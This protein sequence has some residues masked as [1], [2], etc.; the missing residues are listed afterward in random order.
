LQELQKLQDD[1][2]RFENAVAF[3]TV[4]EELGIDNFFDVFELVEMEPIA[5]ASIGQ[6]YKA[7]L[8]ENGATVAL[9]IQ[10][11]DCE[12]IIALDLYGKVICF[13]EFASFP[14]YNE[15]TSV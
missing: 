5:A 9:K 13:V 12:R 6:V 7:I 2:P 3:R 14:K 11:P 8:R 4:E 10:R 15:L 1:V